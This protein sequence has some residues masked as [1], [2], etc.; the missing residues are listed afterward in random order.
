MTDNET[1]LDAGE[2]MLKA[3]VAVKSGNRK[4]GAKLFVAAVED[5]TDGMDYIADGV[6]NAMNAIEADD[7]EDLLDDDDDL[8]EDDDLEAEFDDEDDDLLEDDDETE[9]PASVASFLDID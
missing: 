9:V 6:G 3:Y 1:I 7:D 2:A 5:E 4:L 8:L